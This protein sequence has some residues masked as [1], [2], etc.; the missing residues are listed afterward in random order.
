MGIVAAVFWAAVVMMNGALVGLVIERSRRAVVGF[1]LGFMPVILVPLWLVGLQAMGGDED[2]LELILYFLVATVPWYGLAGLIGSIV[3]T[4]AGA[5]LPLS[6]GAL[7]FGGGAAVCAL[8]ASVIVAA[9]PPYGVG[10]WLTAAP[11]LIAYFGP[12]VIGVLTVLLRQCNDC[13][14]EAS[15]GVA[16]S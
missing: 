7:A 13:N 5:D 6:V 12:Q 16:S 4:R 3:I 14:Q 11:L 8:V 9:W 1:A 10:Y 15:F 2:L